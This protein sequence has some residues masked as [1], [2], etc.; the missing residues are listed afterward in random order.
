M[1]NIYLEDA[2]V[3]AHTAKAQSLK[4]RP[5]SDVTDEHGFQYVNLVQ[6]GGGVLGI[7]LVGF[8]YIL[9]C[10]GIRF[11]RL[12]G[13]SAGAINTMLLAAIGEKHEAKSEKI[14]DK[15]HAL[16]LLSF[17]DTNEK[18]VIKALKINGFI[19]NAIGLYISILVLSFICLLL[20]AMHRHYIYAVFILIFIFVLI[21][22]GL[23]VYFSLQRIKNNQW[24]LCDGD[25]FHA[26]IR[27]ILDDEG[28]CSLADLKNR[29]YLD[30]NHLNYPNEYGKLPASD[31]TV[32]ACDLTNGIKAEFPKDINLYAID[33]TIHPSD[34][35]R[36]SMSIP[37]FFRPFKFTLSRA[38]SF[39]DKVKR[40]QL[41]FK[42][43]NDAYFVDGGV[44]SN[45]PINIFHDPNVKTPR[46]PVI[47][48]DLDEGIKPENE[49]FFDSLF[50]YVFHLF[51]TIRYHNDKNFLAKHQFYQ[52]HCIQSIDVSKYNWLNF[53]L[54]DKEKLALFKQG[55]K[56]GLKYLEDFDWETY[57]KERSAL[58]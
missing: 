30:C 37:I 48:L 25:K 20:I 57:K 12:A 29:A 39:E 15:L 46:L 4:R 24:S 9:E 36:A 42:E 58:Q 1:P 27:H 32:I 47:G 56:K 7:A 33:D 2:E 54:S 50:A 43:G 53:A 6:E 49:N 19:K 26:W 51:N 16:D 22:C 3:K 28:I 52:K 23:F 55:V 5:F 45:F 13:T 21:I 8:T 41:G 31:V 40:R 34:F 38:M 17:A 14:L 18:W 10:A 35:V 44:V 11:W